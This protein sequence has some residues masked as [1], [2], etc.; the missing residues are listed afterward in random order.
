MTMSDADEKPKSDAPARLHTSLQEVLEAERRKLLQVHSLLCC[1]YEVLLYA[2]S[3]DAVSYAEAAHLAANLVDE[4]AERL[5][6]IRLKLLI[7]AERAYRTE[8]GPGPGLTRKRGGVREP[9]VP[10]LH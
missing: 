9:F 1:L 7:E 2:E 5:D 8:D 10:Y 3:D 4:A 6:P